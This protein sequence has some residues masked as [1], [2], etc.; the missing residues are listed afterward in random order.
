MTARQSQNE[1]ENTTLSEIVKPENDLKEWLLEYV[2]KKL[3]PDNFEIT[4]EMIVEV[5]SQEFPEFLLA[6]AE[7]N[8]VRGYEQAMVDLRQCDE[9]V[10]DEYYDEEEDEGE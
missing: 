3:S 5:L 7:E 6:V 8:W 4:V 1:A 9:D 2:G 10:E